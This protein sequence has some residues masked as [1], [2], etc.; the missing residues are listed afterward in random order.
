MV[1]FVPFRFRKRRFCAL[2]QTAVPKPDSSGHGVQ[3]SKADGRAT[4]P[5]KY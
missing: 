1:N 2:K 5:M 3:R 4:A